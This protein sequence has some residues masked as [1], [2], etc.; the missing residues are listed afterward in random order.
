MIRQYVMSLA[1]P[2][3][4]VQHIFWYDFRD[5][6]TDPNNVE[7]N[8]GLVKNDWK[9]PKFSYTAYQQMTLRLGGATPQD[10]FN[11]GAGIAYRF[12]RN[13][14][15]VDVVWGGGRT[16]LPTS[17]QHAQ[18]YDMGGNQLPTEVSGGQVHVSIGADPV[19]VEHA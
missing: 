12:D 9:T 19:F 14:T 6:G 11:S 4:D 10:S 18:A 8:Y 1:Y 5:D 16:N 13:G 2:G 15:V 17:V 7:N 3:L